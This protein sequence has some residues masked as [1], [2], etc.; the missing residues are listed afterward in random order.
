M[1]ERESC[2]YYPGGLL[3]D[4]CGLG[5][6]PQMIATLLEN[7][8]PLTLIVAPVNILTQWKDQLH[9][10]VPDFKV[11][12]YHASSTVQSV[13]R[14]KVAYQ[15]RLYELAE[16]ADERDSGYEDECL[17]VRPLV[18]LTSYGK[19][20]DQKWERKKHTLRRDG[21]HEEAR[22]LGLAK[23]PLH[24][25]HW[26]RI[27]LDECHLIRNHGTTRTKYVMTLRG[28][29]KWGLTA[30]PIHN[31]I[32][33]YQV[34]LG[35]LGLKK[36][37]IVKLFSTHPPLAKH[38]TEKARHQMDQGA[39][40][41]D[42]AIEPH[43]TDEIRV[44]SKDDPF[45]HH[46]DMTLRRTKAQV[47]PPDSDMLPPLTVTVVPVD[48]ASVA[49]HEFYR[50][51]ER[52]TQLEV[53]DI[54]A[55]EQVAADP[56]L[57]NQA[58]FEL[59]LRL[60]QASVNPELVVAG[61]RRK[62]DGLFPLNLLPQSSRSTHPSAASIM[63]RAQ[64]VRFQRTCQVNDMLR[65]IGVPSKT[66]MLG[67]LIATHVAREKSIVFCEFREEMPA[68]RDHLAQLNIQAVQY[69]GT[70]SLAQ[71]QAIVAHMSWTPAAIQ[72]FLRYGPFGLGGA[73]V[74]ADL[75]RLLSRYI[76]Y[77]VI[78][79][80]IQSGNAGLNLQMCSRVYYTSPNWNPCTEIQAWSRAHRMGQLRPV[81]V[82]K[83]VLSGRGP[84]HHSDAT[85]ENTSTIDQRVIE[86]QQEKRQIMADILEDHTLVNN[87]V[88]LCRE[89]L[90]K[91]IASLPLG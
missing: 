14:S 9:R 86:V 56:D 85:R 25:V 64:Q 27:V 54:L 21:L 78:L 20:T 5:K 38:L 48:F 90:K 47:F 81:H 33:D 43:H 49:E 75:V 74:S 41:L 42:L 71:R 16:T 22:R 32:T 36:W 77:D 18:V 1:V 55:N 57:V 3:M 65:D 79:V 45:L 46:H 52:A 8:Q 70:L 7:P 23:T 50:R 10:W 11:L 72:W 83:L 61:Y 63:T 31:G 39:R 4:D 40:V 58:I 82:V 19:L 26:D 69:D 2:R 15:T 17:T 67:D 62:L 84:H 68:L 76:S 51:L 37:E 6:T 34:L 44:I 89:D 24:H 91:M 66:R 53:D 88:E 35:F 28:R 29:I 80:Q 73:R 30:T 13:R 60:R 12:L 87:G 59:V